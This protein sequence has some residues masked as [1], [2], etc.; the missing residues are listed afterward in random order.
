MMTSK[1]PVLSWPG[2]EL[3]ASPDTTGLLPD[4][5]HSY[6]A[7]ARVDE[8]DCFDNLLIHGDNLTVLQALASHYAGTVRCVYIDPPYNTGNAFEHYDD[9]L[10]H[11]HWLSMMRDRLALLRDFLTEDGI[12]AVQIGADEMAYLKVLMDELY[13][14]KQC[15]GQVAIRMSHSAGLKRIARDRRL[16][17]NTEYLLVYYNKQPPTLNPL[18]ERVTEFPVNYFHWILDFPEPGRPGRYC[19]LVEELFRRFPQYFTL[20]RLRAINTS[21]PVLFQREPEIEQFLIE[22]RERVTRKHA[23]VPRLEQSFEHL[24]ADEFERVETD[25]RFY[26]MGSTRQGSRYQLIPLTE[27]TQAVSHVDEHGQVQNS[28]VIANLLGDWWDGFWRDMSRVDVEGGVLMKESKKPERLL[29][30]VLQLCTQPGDL[31]LDAF[32]GS[33]TT[34]AV[35]HKMRRRWIGIEQGDHCHSLAATRLRQVIDGDDPTGITDAV[36]WQGGGGYRACRIAAQGETASDSSMIDD[37]YATAVAG[38]DYSPPDTEQPTL[39]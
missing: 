39:F 2:K 7:A 10:G 4:P 37:A 21:I 29:Q 38:L 22:H 33:G 20:H 19:A 23:E 30:W 31:V 32:L 14:R 24:A 26:F 11:G 25:T 12:I 9:D 18:Y 3:H 34:A 13:G 1:Q 6:L 5:V 17:K 28:F 36:G 27:K 15:I 8:R 35:A 16:I